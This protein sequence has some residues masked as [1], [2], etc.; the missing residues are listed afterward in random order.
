M[1]NLEPKILD[2]LTVIAAKK[3]A[4]QGKSVSPHIASHTFNTCITLAALPIGGIPALILQDLTFLQGNVS[5]FAD[6]LIADS[7]VSGPTASRVY[8]THGDKLGGSRQYCHPD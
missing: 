1:Q 5:A 4:F 8:F 3:P 7:P 2:A 6:A